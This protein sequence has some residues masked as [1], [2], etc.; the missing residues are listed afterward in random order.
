[1]HTAWQ[2]WQTGITD[3]LDGEL[4][5]IVC[6]TRENRLYAVRTPGS[7]LPIFYHISDD[8]IVLASAPKGIFALGDIPRE[9]DEQRIADSL[10]LNYEDRESSFYKNI[11][12]APLGH[13]M[14][15]RSDRVAMH[16]YHDLGDAPAVRFANDADYAEAANELLQRSVVNHMRAET[17]PAATLSSGLDSPSVVV[18]ALEHLARQSGGTAEPLI[19][20]TSVP[21]P[22]W[23][24]RAHGNG[25]VGDESGPVRALARRYPELDAR[26]V[27]SAGRSIDHDLDKIILL[28]EAPPFGIG[29]LHWANDIQRLAAA[30]GRHVIL[31]GASG[32]QTFS[33]SGSSIYAQLLRQ[34]R[35][36]KL[37]RELY[38]IGEPGARWRGIYSRVFK[39]H[40]P[41]NWARKIQQMRGIA[42][43][44]GWPIFSAVNTDYA[45]DMQVDERAEKMGHDHGFSGFVRLRDAMNQMANS[46]VGEAGQ[47]VRSALQTL[48]GVQGRDPM[49]SRKIAEFCAGLPAD[50]YIRN[51]ED[52]LLIKRMMAGRLPEEILAAPRGRQAADKHLRMT[53][54]LPRYHEEIE[55]MG[56]NPDMAQRFD[57][58]RLKRL[59]DSWPEKTPVCDDDHP[60][61]KIALI[62]MNR[63]IATSRFINWVN[64]KN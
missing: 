23:D 8:R 21:E 53:R 43:G 47:A 31:G 37:A 57:V 20:F 27:D 11:R 22:G 35:L 64:G 36:I 14:E 2:K 17:T 44:S 62:G 45:A 5:F 52:R 26:F 55:R 51:G 41:A 34:G 58:P 39:P 42:E 15:V 63:A 32:N 28:A 60:D 18:C 40:L 7:A 1:I 24:G 25:R 30:E 6:D 33:F 54:D 4:A 3:H 13:I 38:H 16:R 46:G 12:S 9:V 49:G 19:S 61:Y 50:Q 56:D 10:I 48:S 59:L 29:N